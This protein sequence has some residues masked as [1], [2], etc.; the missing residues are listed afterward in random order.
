MPKISAPT[1]A[2]HRA[3]RRG[4]LL[5]AGEELLREGG[6]VS[7]TPRSVCERAGLSRSSFYDYFGTKDDLL[8]ALAIEAIEQWDADIEQQLA[9]VEAGLPALRVFVEATMS[10]TAEGRHDI[11]GVLREA[12]LAPSRMEDLMVLHDVLLRPLVRI[13]GDL[14]VASPATAV[15]LVQ[16]LLGAGIQL[17]AHGVDHRVVS[18]DVFSL[19]ARG[20]LA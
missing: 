7:V 5:R 12:D 14:E 8:A 11:A 17:V 19:V 4:S 15:I 2:E 16:G 18:D 6:L 20:L 3:S 9:G 10:M 13:L 1:V